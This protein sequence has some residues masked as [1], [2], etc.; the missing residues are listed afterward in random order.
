[1]Q[2]FY[3]CLVILS[4]Q[5]PFYMQLRWSVC[6]THAPSIANGSHDAPLHTALQHAFPKKQ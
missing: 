3:H 1:M 6:E 5:L 2:A 4:Q